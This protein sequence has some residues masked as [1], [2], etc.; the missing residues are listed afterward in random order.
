MLK[1]EYHFEETDDIELIKHVERNCCLYNKKMREFKTVDKR[2][3][4]TQIGAILTNKKTGRYN[5]LR[6]Y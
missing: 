5:N 1:M 2:E 3:V 6:K 4:W